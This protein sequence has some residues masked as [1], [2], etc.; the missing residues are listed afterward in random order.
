MSVYVLR[1]L[2]RLPKGAPLADLLT[3]R[4]AEPRP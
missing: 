1:E 2:L 4:A 3:R